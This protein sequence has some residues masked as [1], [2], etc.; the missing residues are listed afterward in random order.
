M[1]HLK[2]CKWG[3]WTKDDYTD[4]LDVKRLE[5]MFGQEKSN[6]DGM[7]AVLFIDARTMFKS[8]L[9]FTMV[10]AKHNHG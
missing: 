3:E 5:S 7:H 8:L 2:G 1:K 9:C 10:N 4:F 6:Q